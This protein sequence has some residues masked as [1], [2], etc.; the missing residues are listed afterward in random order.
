MLKKKKKKEERKKMFLREAILHYINA[1]GLGSTKG[2]LGLR[3]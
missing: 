2:G 1:V 3:S